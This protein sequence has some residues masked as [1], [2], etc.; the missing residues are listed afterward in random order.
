MPPRSP[1]SSPS[2]GRARVR[3]PPSAGPSCAASSGPP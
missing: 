3:R 2:T 1:A